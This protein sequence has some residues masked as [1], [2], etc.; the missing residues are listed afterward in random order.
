MADP[1]NEQPITDAELRASLQVDRKTVYCWRKRGMPHVKRH[2]RVL[3][4]RSE[5]AR[6]WG[7][8]WETL[9]RTMR[10]SYPHR[11]RGGGQHVGK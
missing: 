9:R 8:T 1:R 7:V 4:Y 6:W 3:Y 10:K 5:V 11:T 2:N